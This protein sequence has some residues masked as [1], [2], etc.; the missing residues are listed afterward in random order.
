MVCTLKQINLLC[1]VTRVWFLAQL[2]FLREPNQVDIAKTLKRV[3]KTRDVILDDIVLNFSHFLAIY[4]E[5]LYWLTDYQLALYFSL[6]DKKKNF[7]GT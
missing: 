4:I 6:D 5:I 2:V 3:S 1:G 7:L